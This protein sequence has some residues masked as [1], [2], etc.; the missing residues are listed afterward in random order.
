MM[1]VHA[2]CEGNHFLGRL[3]CCL[4]YA[5]SS[6]AT[7]KEQ[8]GWFFCNLYWCQYDLYGMSAEV[9]EESKRNLEGCCFCCGSMKFSL[10]SRWEGFTQVWWH[11]SLIYGNCSLCIGSIGWILGCLCLVCTYYMQQYVI[12][13]V[14]HHTKFLNRVSMCNK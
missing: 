3:G 11:S 8:V 10:L 9:L 4:W 12:V 14:H 13:N 1:Q 7:S 2:K 6:D 5:S